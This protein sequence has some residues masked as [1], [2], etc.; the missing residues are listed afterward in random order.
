MDEK[1]WKGFTQSKAIISKDVGGQFSIFDGAV[2]GVNMKL[3]EDKLI[4]QKWR[5]QNWPDEHYS[6][7]S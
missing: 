5:F 7:V 3:E 1:R 4:V 2:T 6:T